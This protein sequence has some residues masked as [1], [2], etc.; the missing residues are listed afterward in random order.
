MSIQNI[1]LEEFNKIK[2]KIKEE[3]YTFYVYSFAVSQEGTLFT[4][5]PIAFEE[6]P[7][8][9]NIVLPFDESEIRLD[10]I[11]EIQ[12]AVVT[13]LIDLTVT[14]ENGIIEC[15]TIYNGEEISA[16]KDINALISFLQLMEEDDTEA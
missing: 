15:I 12:N 8:K 9:D 4:N 14:E 5:A 10:F 16:L 11:G 2:E 13:D 3:R 1:V 7:D 6:K